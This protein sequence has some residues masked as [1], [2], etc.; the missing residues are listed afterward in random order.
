MPLK[1]PT[2]SGRKKSP[3]FKGEKDERPVTQKGVTLRDLIRG[4]PEKDDFEAIEKEVEDASDRSAAIVVAAV[5]DRYLEWAILE[6]LD[7]KDDKTRRNLTS[8]G[9]ALDGFFSKIHLAYAMGLINRQKRNELDL[10][11]RIRN[12]FAHS[13]KNIT[14]DTSSI[15]EECKTFKPLRALGPNPSARTKYISAC[16]RITKILIAIKTAK[17]LIGSGKVDD[18][19]LRAKIAGLEKNMLILS[20]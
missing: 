17:D 19:D 20:Q 8:N 1:P 9:G 5:I 18:E 2:P 4:M 13:A 7:R 12:T 10:I 15:T 16:N 6:A 11:R 14:F 3:R